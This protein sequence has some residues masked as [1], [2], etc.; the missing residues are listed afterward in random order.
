MLPY[1][2]NKHNKVFVVFDRHV[3]VY[4]HMC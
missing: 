2:N 4:L 3:I 1:F